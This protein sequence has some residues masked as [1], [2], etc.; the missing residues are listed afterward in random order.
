MELTLQNLEDDVR[1]RLYMVEELEHDLTSNQMYPGKRLT[2]VG[3]QAWPDLLREA[4]EFHDPEWL[5]HQSRQPGFWLEHEVSVR[6]GKSYTKVVPRDAAKTLAE[7]QFM[8][9]YLR[10]VARRAIEDGLELEVVRLKEVERPRSISLQ[11]IG[12]RVD[13]QLLLESLRQNHGI[14][15]FLNIPP[16]PN[17]GLGV[18]I[19]PR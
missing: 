1:T 3:S 11:L 4:L 12:A 13:P 17:S 16:G 8:R 9:Y 18:V 19:V 7:G 5:E 10:A 14:E 2:V 6:K 15:P